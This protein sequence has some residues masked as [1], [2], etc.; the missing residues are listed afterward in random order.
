[1]EFNL[2]Y[3]DVI[4]FL[5]L[6][7]LIQKYADEITLSEISDGS[8]VNDL[9]SNSYNLDYKQNF[10]ENLSQKSP[11]GTILDFV[12][13]KKSKLQI[14]FSVSHL[15][16]RITIVF[17]C[18][19]DEFEWYSN[20]PVALSLLHDDVYVN[21]HFNDQLD[22]DTMYYIKKKLLEIKINYPNYDI[23]FTG[24]SLGGAVCTLAAYII[25]RELKSLEITVVSFGSPRIGNNKWSESF[26]NTDKL[27]NYRITNN[28][29]VLTSLPILNYTHVGINLNLGYNELNLYDK[30]NQYPWY[31]F[32]IFNCWNYDKRDTKS[33]MSSL[34]KNKW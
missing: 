18:I 23:Y 19:N 2:E 6:I 17:N 21:S 8:F 30:S 12:F 34:T 32:S 14:A 1:M 7:I 26:E 16:T 28:G 22:E 20:T 3:S 33:Y 10:V 15:S 11:N 13:D 9:E 5:S 4:D 25:I 27:I 31:Q 29:D 24:Y